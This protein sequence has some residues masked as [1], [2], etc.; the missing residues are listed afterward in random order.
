MRPGKTLTIS[1]SI[2]AL[3]AIGACI[4][5]PGTME[6]SDAANDKRNAKD[7]IL[8]TEDG[9]NISVSHFVDDKPNVCLLAHGFMGS[10]HM[11][12]ITGLTEKLSQYF[13]VIT[14]DFRGH[15]E[16]SGVHSGTKELYDVKAVLD[17]ARN[18]GY[19]K[20]AF[21]GFSLG[22]IQGIYAAAKFHNMDA[23]VT[24]GTPA[25]AEAV[26][27][28][29]KWLFWL[30]N[31][32]FGRIVLRIWVRLD[33]SAEFPRPVTVVGQVSPIPMLIVHGRDD[34][35]VELKEAQTLYE[36]AK[37]PK[38]LVIIEGMKHPP[39]LPVE[40]YDTVVSWLT[41]LLRQ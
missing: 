35:L 12:Y 2:I 26:I 14:F 23:L 15:G 11:P 16:S 25:D 4:S 17:Y 7:F 33:G 34:T 5:S 31:N 20:I 24:V 1:V 21:V 37:E 38:E 36:K 39:D 3:L 30:T 27:S 10:K 6:Y 19:Q 8:L 40:F 41:E 28:N 29:A 18:Y 13:D 22:G 9:I 32:W